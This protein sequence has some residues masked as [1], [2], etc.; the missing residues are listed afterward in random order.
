MTLLWLWYRPWAA[1]LIQTLASELPYAT[2]AAL[3]R[4]KREQKRIEIRYVKQPSWNLAHIEFP[5][6]VCFL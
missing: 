2:H 6:N 4:Q 3:K 5:G 1:S